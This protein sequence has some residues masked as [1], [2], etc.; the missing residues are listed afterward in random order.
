MIADEPTLTFQKIESTSRSQNDVGQGKMTNHSSD[1]P[2][3]IIDISISGFRGFSEKTTIN[4]AIPNGKPGS[5][6]TVF[7]GNNNSGKSTILE[8]IALLSSEAEKNFPIAIR[9]ADT[10]NS[11]EIAGTLNNGHPKQIFKSNDVNKD[12]V[13]KHTGT[14]PFPMNIMYIPS[15]RRLPINSSPNMADNQYADN[16]N[17]SPDRWQHINKIA[18]RMATWEARKKDINKVLYAIL[19]KTFQ[20]SVDQLQA[21][22]DSKN[23][24][25]LIR[26]GLHRHFSDSLGDGACGIFYYS[27]C[28]S[29]LNNNSILVFDEPE[30]SLN[31]YIQ[32]RLFEHISETTKDRQIIIS[33]HSPYFIG[34]DE[35]INGCKI[36]RVSN[37][38][39]G[40]K[41]NELILD[42][43]VKYFFENA[44]RNYQSS[45]L[46]GIEAREIFFVPDNVIVLEG[47]DDKYFYPKL[48]REINKI[49]PGNYYGYGAGGKDNIINIFHIFESLGYRKV[50]AILDKC[51]DDKTKNELIK[52]TNYIVQEIPTYDIRD[53]EDKNIV[54]IFDKNGKIKKSEFNDKY[55]DDVIKMA[56]QLINYFK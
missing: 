9:N 32:Q 8:S 30:C 25:L 2:L 50:A 13:T 51:D 31:P 44:T 28:L 15:R 1:G 36:V 4:L 20:W 35:I 48:F 43:A 55:K 34:F 54:G 14:N 18:H 26:S 17:F 52:F 29:T 53:K 21:G 40:T 5:G 7:V 27:D 19:D 47:Q 38:G 37:P 22:G 41:V 16:F 46:Y 12:V 56:D 49:I 3:R 24:G 42:G 39:E 33:T 11:V 10:D 6:L 23:K 45:Y